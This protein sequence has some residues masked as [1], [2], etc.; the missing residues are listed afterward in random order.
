MSNGRHFWV[1]SAQQ[2]SKYDKT[3]KNDQTQKYPNSADFY[4]TTRNRKNHFLTALSH[5]R[6]KK[7]FLAT[8]YH[9]G[10]PENATNTFCQGYPNHQNINK[11]ASPNTTPRKNQK[12]RRGLFFKSVFAL[13]KLKTKVRTVLLKTKMDT[14]SILFRNL[15][16]SSK[17][18]KKRPKKVLVAP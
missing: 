6:R 1:A 12:T 9:T 5:A 17:T 11:N 13:G 3:I 14:L 15:Q 8:L 7:H 2:A 18:S 10:Q 4:S 16:K